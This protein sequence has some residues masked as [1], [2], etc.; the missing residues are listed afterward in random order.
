MKLK[1]NV[2]MMGKLKGAIIDVESVANVPSE[3]FWRKRLNDSLIDNCVEIV[4]QR[5]R[6]TSGER[7]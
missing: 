5:K 6:K 3:L 7:L 4:K 2:A 1:L